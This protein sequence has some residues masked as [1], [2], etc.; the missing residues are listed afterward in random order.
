MNPDVY[1]AIRDEEV[2]KLRAER[3]EDAR[4]LDR[5]VELLDGLVLGAEFV[6][7][8]TLPAYAHLD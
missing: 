3:G 6:P 4:C 7:F 8:L 2:A 1:C 5:A